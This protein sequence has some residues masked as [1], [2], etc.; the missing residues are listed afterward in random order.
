MSAQRRDRLLTGVGNSRKP[1]FFFRRTVHAGSGNTM[2][3]PVIT[4][5]IYPAEASVQ[6][7]LI[8]LWRSEWSQTDYNWLEALYGDYSKTLTIV[9]MIARVDDQPVA[10]ATV[11]L[12]RNSPEVCLLGNVV[13]LKPYRGRG[14]GAAVTDAAVAY[15]FDAGCRIACLG[16][17]RV[18]GNVYKRI[19]FEYL[20][21]CIMCR[22]AGSEQ[23][24]DI[25]LFA[26]GQATKIRNANWG[27]MP[28]LVSL[29][30][31]SLPDT[32]LD[33]P[34]GLFSVKSADPVRCVSAFAAI[35]DQTRQRGGLMLTLASQ[36]GS[37][38][39]GFGS[40][41]PGPSPGRTHQAVLDVA[42]HD[43]YSG[44]LGEIIDRLRYEATQR[45]VEVLRA[46]VGTEESLKTSALTVAGFRPAGR[47]SDHFQ[48]R[49]GAM[50]AIV[51]DAKLS[52][53]C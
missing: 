32:V 38:V 5:H 41:T 37:R 22:S 2:K 1:T 8:S 19:G 40:L 7:D 24:D 9:S 6:Q 12:P 29:L 48:L 45:G 26:S 42:A 47:L 35:H 53:M 39:F 46:F 36:S 28:G 27:D 51:L 44:S 23:H 34:R 49:N 14:L 3:Q 15:G 21:G 33:Y 20:S 11:N 43:R 18:R 25:N 52:G 16:S 31:Q 30:T 13:T 4:Q 10:T 50:D 17:S